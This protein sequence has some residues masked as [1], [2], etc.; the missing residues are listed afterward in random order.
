MQT[1]TMSD[2]ISDNIPFIV[3]TLSEITGRYIYIENDDNFSIGLMA[4]QEALERYEEDKG[5]FYPFAK[6]VIK[7]RIQSYLKKESK[8]NSLLSLDSME[9]CGVEIEDKRMYDDEKIILKDEI[10]LFI[11]EINSFGFTL[12][13]L[14]EES[15][16]HK[17]TRKNTIDISRKVSKDSLLTTFMFQKRRLP[18][19]QISTKFTITERILKKSKKFIISVIIILFK[20]FITL[21]EWIK[22]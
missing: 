12:D 3:K 14:V 21:K 5:E 2:L 18:V 6:L 13:E 8:E 4:F 19:K 16:K 10:G 17:D 22:E 11:K 9:E 20:N 15:P 7:S 1:S